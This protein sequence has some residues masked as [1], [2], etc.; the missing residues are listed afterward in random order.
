[1]KLPNHSDDKPTILIMAHMD[2]HGSL[3]NKK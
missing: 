1:M 3:M 2:E